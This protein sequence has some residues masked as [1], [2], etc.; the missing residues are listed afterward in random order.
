MALRE[1]Q[2]INASSMADIAFLLLIFFLVSATIQIDSGIRRKLPEYHSTPIKNEIK[3]RNLMEI[4]VNRNNELMVE[5]QLMPIDELRAATKEFILNPDNKDNLPVI[6]EGNNQILGNFRL[7]KNHVISL[8]NDRGTSYSMYITVQNEL[9]A[10]Y[11]ELRDELAREKFSKGYEDITSEQR[12]AI[13]EALP[14]RISEA[15]IN[16]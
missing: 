1:I 14:I 2:Q 3:P 16:E 6:S 7:A 15:E 9:T 13:N 12:T 10:A 11:I 4:Y 8:K 5:Q